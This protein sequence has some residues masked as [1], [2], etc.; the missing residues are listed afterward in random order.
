MRTASVKK[1]SL[2][3]VA[4][5]MADMDPPRNSNVRAEAALNRA[6]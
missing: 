4:T 2:S 3:N 5:S 1:R 6:E